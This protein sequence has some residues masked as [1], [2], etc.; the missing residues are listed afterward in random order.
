VEV[1]ARSLRRLHSLA[2]LHRLV[3]LEARSTRMGLCAAVEMRPL[4]FLRIGVRGDRMPARMRR[5]ASESERD[6]ELPELRCS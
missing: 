1:A 6:Y 3:N 4:D 2:V 5:R